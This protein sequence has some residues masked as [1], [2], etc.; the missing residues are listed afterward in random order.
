[1]GTNA[2]PRQG[3]NAAKPSNE[4]ASSEKIWSNEFK[5]KAVLLRYHC[6]TK[7]DELVFRRER[8]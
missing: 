6:T 4:V 5:A 2:M 7:G 3:I 8:R 1:M